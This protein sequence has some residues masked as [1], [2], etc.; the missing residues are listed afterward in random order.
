[1]RSRNSRKRYSKK[2]KMSRGN[3]VVLYPSLY[4]SLLM[5][6]NYSVT[7][8]DAAATAGAFFGA[9]LV[10]SFQALVNL[11]PY[12][13]QYRVEKVTLK[14]MFAELPNHVQCHMAT[15]HSADGA[16]VGASTPTL[17]S[18]KS[19]RDWQVFSIQQNTP[20][21]VWKM[22]I[23]D[24]NECDYTD[25]PAAT[26]VADSQFIVGGVQFFVTQIVSGNT[27]ASVFAMVQFKVRL[28]GKQA[29]SV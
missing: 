22:D 15:T 21:K 25:I 24:L 3:T 11:R 5:Y 9:N 14:L 13:S 1:M 20:K 29:I 23:N 4:D 16:T 12:F 28:K 26:I 17:A 6:F 8:T 10:Q 27:L 18:I 19:Y 7:Y 2:Q